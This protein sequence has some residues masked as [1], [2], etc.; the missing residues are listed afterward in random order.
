MDN[1][2]SK[3]IFIK[4]HDNN[5]YYLENDGKKYLTFIQ[6]KCDKELKISNNIV[7]VT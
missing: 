7:S 3:K 5:I 1:L 4:N 2:K 6:I